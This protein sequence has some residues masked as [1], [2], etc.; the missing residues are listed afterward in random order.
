MVP[1]QEVPRL[2]SER[3]RLNGTGHSSCGRAYPDTDPFSDSFDGIISDCAEKWKANAD[4]GKKVMW[5]CF[6]ECGIFITICRYGIL[7]LSCDI[8]KSGEL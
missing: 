1:D 7:L 5:D 2:V 6:E 4:D 8:I 3:P